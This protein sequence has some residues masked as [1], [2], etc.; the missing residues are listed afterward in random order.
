MYCFLQIFCRSEFLKF[1]IGKR[2]QYRYNNG[3]ISMPQEALG[4]AKY[5]KSF[6]SVHTGYIYAESSFTLSF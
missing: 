1:R 6:I 4:A 5:A 2:E 3:K